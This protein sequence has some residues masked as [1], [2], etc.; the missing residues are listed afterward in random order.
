MARLSRVLYLS[1][2][3]LLEPLGQSQILPYLEGLSS[4]GAKITLLS[5]EKPGDMAPGSVLFRRVRLRLE[6]A[7]I[8]WVPLSYHKRL[9]ILAKSFDL[10]VGTLKA[11]TL[12]IKNQVGIVHCRSYVAALMGWVLKRMLGVRLL[13]DMRGF[14]AD[15]RVE[16]G[17]WPAGGFLYRLAKRL[18]HRLLRDADEIVT[19]TDRARLTVEQWPGVEVS[20]VTVIP[21]CVDLERFS[22]P[23][24]NGSP[25]S[26]PVFIYTGSVGTW[27]LLREMLQFI[28][29]AIKRFPCARFLL[30]TRN[31]EE[32]D[33]ELR[34]IRL[35][36]DTVRVASAAPAEVPGWLAR[37]DAGLAFYKPG[38]ARQATCPTKIGEYLAMG[39]P[40]VVNDAVGD[41][42]GV[43]GTNAVGTV[44]SEFSVEAYGRALDQL[45]KLW[46]DPNLA[47]RCRRVAESHFSLQLGVGRYWAIYQRLA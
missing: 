43:V 23:A 33:R 5:F 10:L 42:E 13:F 17:L 46:S 1:Y 6:T 45:Q 39:L 18:E 11:A 40:V 20:Q 36:P 32:A 27:Y 9:A 29:V 14:W 16:G 22:A 25:N 19:L 21:T 28:D 41:V 47:L 7:G 3:G 35:T 8:H 2:D 15:E 38:W 26:S 30:V 31:R 44:L 12:V 37:A 34:Q 24:S 4:R